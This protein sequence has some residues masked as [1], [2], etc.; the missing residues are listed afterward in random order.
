MEMV[1]EDPDEEAARA[2]YQ[3]DIHWLVDSSAAI[4]HSFEALVV[5][6]A[7]Q[8]LGLRMGNPESAGSEREEEEEEKIAEDEHG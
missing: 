5:L 4:A 2:Q 8:L 7:D 3:A 1:D 6:L